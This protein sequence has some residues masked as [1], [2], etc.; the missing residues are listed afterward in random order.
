MYVGISSRLRLNICVSAD[1]IKSAGNDFNSVKT[2]LR[3]GKSLDSHDGIVKT[4][5]IRHG[6]LFDTGASRV[7]S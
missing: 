2:D 4:G 3:G 6:L 7:T 5:P 1:N